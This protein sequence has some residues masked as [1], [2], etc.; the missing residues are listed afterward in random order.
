M[1]AL[2]KKRSKS[3]LIALILSISALNSCT[4]KGVQYDLDTLTNI[5]E[6][7]RV[8]ILEASLADVYTLAGGTYIG[9]S[10][11]YSQYSLPIENVTIIGTAHYPELA[12]IQP[13]NPDLVIYSNKKQ[14]HV[15]IASKLNELKINT[16]GCSIESFDDYLNLLNSFTTLLGNSDLYKTYGSDIKNNIDSLIAQA[17]T[18]ETSKVMFVRAK[19]TDYSVIG[20]DNF[21][22]DMLNDLNTTNVLPESYIFNENQ[23]SFLL[24]QN[25]DY[26][27][28]TYMGTKNKETSKKYL[29]EH[30]L[31]LESFKTINASVNNNIYELDPALFNYKPN[32]RWYE[33]Y[34]I[35]YNYLYD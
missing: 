32:S 21:V 6:P 7:T 22:V 3:L 25:P 4:T 17:S 29:E 16:Y 2:Q 13:L 8:V 30:L 20:T 9:I 24:S 27:F 12:K 31:N 15:D 5:K 23:L 26:V 14:S 18:K 35:L 19:S 34:Q 1:Q 28:Y 11:D 33:A 10:D